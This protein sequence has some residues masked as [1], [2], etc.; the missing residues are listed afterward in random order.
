[1]FAGSDL[2]SGPRSARHEH[3]QDGKDSGNDGQPGGDQIAPHEHGAVLGAFEQVI[4]VGGRVAVATLLVEDAALGSGS[5][6]PCR[7]SADQ[8]LR[9]ISRGTRDPAHRSRYG[10]TCPH[11]HPNMPLRGCPVARLPEKT[12]AGS[13]VGDLRGYLGSPQTRPPVSFSPMLHQKKSR[14]YRYAMILRLCL[15]EK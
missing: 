1:M 2:R 10:L 5:F 7:S 12:S 4:E 8:H 9:R 6:F 11:G 13:T 15:T 3:T 14:R